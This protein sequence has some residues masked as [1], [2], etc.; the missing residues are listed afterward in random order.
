MTAVPRQIWTKTEQQGLGEKEEEKRRQ[1]ERGALLLLLRRRRTE[2]PSDRVLVVVRSGSSMSAAIQKRERES[3]RL[4][5]DP[6]PAARALLLDHH[7][8]RLA[9]L[10]RM[11]SIV[12]SS[13]RLSS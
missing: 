1:I 4:Q 3:T 11:Y 2:S 6:R 12:S 9:C 13:T 7:L 8:H 10:P 5:V